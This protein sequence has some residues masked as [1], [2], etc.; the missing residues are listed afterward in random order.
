M[1]NIKWNRLHLQNI[2]SFFCHY[3]KYVF[4]NLVQECKL[5]REKNGLGMWAMATTPSLQAVL[6]AAPKSR[7]QCPCWAGLWTAG[8][9]LVSACN[10]LCFSALKK[11]NNNNTFLKSSMRR[12]N[13]VLPPLVIPRPGQRGTNQLW[14]VPPCCCTASSTGFVRWRVLIRHPGRAQA[15]NSK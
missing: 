6:V 14:C 7:L 4:F 13:K 8:W 5:Y 9:N 3:L 1:S 10:S 12:Q 11:N 15:R 2:F